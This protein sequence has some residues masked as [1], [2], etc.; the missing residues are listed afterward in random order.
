MDPVVFRKILE[1]GRRNGSTFF[2]IL[3]GEPLMYPGLLDLLAGYPDCYFQV[4][5]NGTLLTDSVAA[6]MREL[7]NVTP[8]VS[9]EGLDRVSDERRGGEHVYAKAMAALEACRRHRLITGV[10]AS[11]CR[12]N[13][14]EV[15]SES[16][17]ADMVRRGAHYVWYYIYRPAGG[18]PTPELALSADEIAALRRF[19]V[20]QRMRQPVI[21]VDA[22]WDQEG[23]AI[24]PAATGI[25]HHV[26]PSGW[27]E[28]CPPIQFAVERVTPD[29]DPVALFDRSA[30]L[31]DFRGWCAAQTRGCVLLEQ[32]AALA[33]RMAK[34]GATDTSGRAGALAALAAAR[35]CAGHHLPGREVPETSWAYRFAKKRFFFGFGAYG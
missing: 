8:L 31:K 35:P 6:R 32:P 16:F 17:L 7:G 12:S 2:G 20:E 26:N 4:F 5:T 10:A 28:P 24:C 21:I 33:E 25:S 13:F 29:S 11:V 34:A 15:V 1:A 3:G 18:R 30:F 27:I 23:R 19:I 14:A 22:Y 9:V